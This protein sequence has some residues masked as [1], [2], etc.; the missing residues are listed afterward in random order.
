MRWMVILLLG[1][2]LLVAGCGAA[3]STTTT[4]AL[5]TTTTAAPTTTTTIATTTTT[6]APT[7]TTTA[8]STASSTVSAAELQQY[9]AALTAW[10]AAFDNP[11]DTSFMNITDPTTATAADIAQADTAST[12]IHKI[13]DQLAAIKPPA[14]L[15]AV[16]NKMVSAFQTEVASMDEFITALKS[17]DAAKM[18]SAHDAGVQHANDLTP[19]LNELMAAIGGQ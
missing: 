19:L 9:A 1:G 13:Q 5:P 14:Q 2:V 17:K 4:T 16:H 7:T 8:I 12:F 18:K 3:T 15:A 10:G 11:P 6:A